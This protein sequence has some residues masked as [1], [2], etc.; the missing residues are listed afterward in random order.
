LFKPIKKTLLHGRYHNITVR[1]FYGSSDLISTRNVR[2]D[3]KS[4]KAHPEVGKG[5]SE[6]TNSGMFILTGA[7]PWL[8]LESACKAYST[9]AVQQKYS[10]V[11]FG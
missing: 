1:S 11:I 9:V 6:M 7:G 5:K 8:T 2:R 10:T 3:R 4:E